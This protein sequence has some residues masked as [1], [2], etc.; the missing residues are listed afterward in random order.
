MKKRELCG[1]EDLAR[2]V[3]EYTVREALGLVVAGSYED[4]KKSA[5]EVVKEAISDIFSE[6]FELLCEFVGLD[7]R[8]IRHYVLACYERKKKKIAV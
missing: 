3:V 4:E 6:D 8:K 7:A 5:E 2:T 1:L